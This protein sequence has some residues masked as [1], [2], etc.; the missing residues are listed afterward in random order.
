MDTTVI[1]LIEDS[2]DDARIIADAL[3]GVIPRDRLCTCVT[4]VEALDFVHCRGKF[5]QRNPAALPVLVIL[6]LGLP[7]LHGFDVLREIRSYPPTRLLPVTVL[8]GSDNQADVANAAELGANS[9]VR[10][11]MDLSQMA[12]RLRQL[13]VY[14]LELNI[15]PPARPR[16]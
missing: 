5:A 2:P 6:D 12:D 11:P 13:A 9:F 10:K 3:A 15:P 8:S 16:Q 4:G 14:W 7:Q 1:L